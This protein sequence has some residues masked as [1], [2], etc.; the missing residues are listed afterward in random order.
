MA[1]KVDGQ[2]RIEI[3]DIRSVE[4]GDDFGTFML[5]LYGR[6]YESVNVIIDA[7]GEPEDFAKL[8]HTALHDAYG[9]DEE[10]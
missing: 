4:V 10:E 7:S 6:D 2:Q 5:T 8:L 3:E 9:L 1:I